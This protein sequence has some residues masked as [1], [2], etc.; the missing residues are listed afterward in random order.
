MV[1]GA[2]E[3]VHRFQPKTNAGGNFN[4]RFEAARPWLE[5]K[6]VLDIGAARGFINLHRRIE[7]VAQRC[8]SV[9]IDARV[10]ADMR[11]AGVEAV[12]GDAQALDLD[13]KFD[14]IFAGELIEH[15]DN[16]RGFFASVRRTLKEGGHLVLTTPNAF[17]YTG[18][19]YRLGHNK[20][21]VNDDHMAWFCEATL[22]QLLTRMDFEIVRLDYVKHRTHGQFRSLVA[23][24]IKVLLPSRLAES[25][26]FAVARPR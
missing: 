6:T 8:L 4:F 22:R 26:I 21:P 12:V 24:T 25:T 14:V 5:G 9:D 1:T 20:V 11:A 23:R 17:L 18:F 3:R 13:E 19:L 7:E 10:V 15:L 2:T 16:Y